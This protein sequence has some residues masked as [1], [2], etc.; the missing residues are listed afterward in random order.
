MFPVGAVE[1]SSAR[2]NGLLWAYSCIRE[3]CLRSGLAKGEA[4]DVA[5]DA[6]LW[7]LRNR[8][9]APSFSALW[10]EKVSKNFVRR[11]LRARTVRLTRESQAANALPLASDEANSFENRDVP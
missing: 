8:Q 3:Q 5:Q 1:R 2:E 9:Y 6:F 10:L 7:V 4:E 11:S